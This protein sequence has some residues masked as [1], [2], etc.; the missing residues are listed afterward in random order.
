M[1]LTLAICMYN[2]EKNIV[3]TLESVVAQT[4]QDFHL[5][6]VDDFSTDCSAEMVE[7]FF[8]THPRQYEMVH[9]EKNQGL[10]YARHFAERQATTRYMMFLDAD[11]ILLPNAIQK[12]YEK[13]T[14]DAY[15]MA[16][17]CYLDY[18]D[19]RGRKIGGGLYLGDTDKATFLARAQKGKLIF[20]Q[21]TAIYDRELG[22]S[23]GR[24]EDLNETQDDGTIIRW[25]DYCED[26]DFWTRMS[27]FYT[28]GKAIIIVPEVLCHYRKQTTSMSTNAY[29]MSLRMRY[30]KANVRRRRQGEQDL[31]FKDFYRSLSTDELENLQH[32]AEAADA[33]RNGVFQLRA[34]HPLKGLHLIC[35]SITLRPGYL[36]DKIR[37]N[38]IKH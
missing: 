2:A 12:M 26:L 3:E 18:I 36:V 33:L 24:Y 32:D 7:S 5:L 29:R 20:M 16:V 37:H 15:L 23:I 22:I 28:E 1:E 38:L 8:A 4:M 31:T 21:S 11:D 27:D 19:E 6:I 25:Q 10:C 30:I 34:L 35:H 13:I 17:G 14:S 9:L